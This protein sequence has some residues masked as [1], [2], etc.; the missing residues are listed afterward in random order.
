[1]IA[2]LQKE[3]DLLNDMIRQNDEEFT[4]EIQRYNNALYEMQETIR[5]YEVR[6]D[7]NR[8]LE[9]TIDDLEHKIIRLK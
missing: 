3:V 9:A 5:E 6:M 7:K 4:M 1:M 8:D 2:N